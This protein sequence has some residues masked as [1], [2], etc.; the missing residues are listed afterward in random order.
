LVL[1]LVDELVSVF[2]LSA[3]GQLKQ[4]MGGGRPSVVDSGFLYWGVRE[5]RDV[6]VIDF[7]TSRLTTD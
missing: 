1:S 6:G 2:V 4:K 3:S 5:I 7:T